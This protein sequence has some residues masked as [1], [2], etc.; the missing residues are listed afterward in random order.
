MSFLLLL[1]Y[2]PFFRFVTALALGIYVAVAFECEFLEYL[3][4]SIVA[5]LFIL[6]G[7]VFAPRIF[8][9]YRNRWLPGF[10]FAV[11][12]FQT[13]MILGTS[14][15]PS[16]FDRE[17]PVEAIAKVRDVDLT[18]SGYYRFTVKP[19][20]VTANDSVP[21][22]SRDHWQIIVEPDDSAHLAA[23]Q[24]GDE[25]FFRA[26]LSGHYG[27]TNPSVFNYG[28]YLLRNGISAIVFVQEGDFKREGRSSVVGVGDR[29]RHIRSKARRVYR[30]HGIEGRNLQVLSALSLGMQDELSDEVRDRFIH[31]GAIHLLAVSGLH[32]GIVFLFLN[33]LA[34]LFLPQ[35]SLVRLLIVV[36][37]LVFFAMLAGGSPS[38]FRAVVM[39]S[40]VQIGRVYRRGG[41]IYNLLGVSAFIILLVRPMSLFHVGF[42]LSHLAVAGIVTFYPVFREIYAGNKPFIRGPVELTSVSLS[43]QL[44]TFPFS[45][46]IFRAFPSWFLLSNFFLLPLVAPVLVL[47][48]L[49]IGF[50]EFPL[51]A[52]MVAGVLDDL[53]A[54]MNAMVEWL[55][56]LPSAY[57]QGLGFKGMTMVLLYLLM[58]V[59]GLW[60][61]H[62]RVAFVKQALVLSLAVVLVSGFTYLDKRHTDAFV[63]FEA[64]RDNVVGVIRAGEGRVYTSDNMNEDELAFVASGFFSEHAL[65]TERRALFSNDRF[66]GKMQ[67]F[68]GPNGLYLVI[69]EG[70]VDNVHVDPTNWREVSGVVLAGEVEGDVPALMERLDCSRLVVAGNCPPW[71]AEKWL[72]DVHSMNVSLHRISEAGAYVDVR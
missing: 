59:L 45:V 11:F 23:V 37:G 64:G 19:L 9:N 18:G 65:N 53:L 16:R 17:H 62:R 1:K 70:C 33:S 42:W 5:T 3:C 35:R 61:H 38:V 34:G 54:F 28:K 7:V 14:S 22:R 29:L 47:A 72:E 57:V 50:S 41:N 15:L 27:P 21:L 68:R 30:T 10:V 44:G 48:K 24:P 31:S 36:S 71:E 4:F 8:K 56:S 12:L 46:Y 6:V 20:T 52:A 58:I 13:G 43:A 32:V 51:L 40:I 2:V 67:I 39:L 26:C 66:K 49:L 63:V 69:G 60:W 25:V 55:N